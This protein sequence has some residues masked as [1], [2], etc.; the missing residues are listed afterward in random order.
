MSSGIRLACCDMTYRAG[1]ELWN[2]RTMEFSLP[3]NTTVSARLRGVKHK[4]VVP[5]GEKTTA[6]WTSK[7]YSAAFVVFAK[8]DLEQ[9]CT[10]YG[11]NEKGLKFSALTF[12]GSEYQKADDAGLFVGQLGAW[13]LDQFATC[14]E[15]ADAIGSVQIWAPAVSLFQLH[16]AISDQEGN[17]ISLRYD[18]GKAL[19]EKNPVGILTNDP[20]LTIQLQNLG[21]YNHLKSEPPAP[22]EIN[23]GVVAPPP[24]SA[25][26]TGLP[27]GFSPTDRFCRLGVFARLMELPSQKEAMVHGFHLANAMD[28][29][30][31]VVK[32]EEGEKLCAETQRWAVVANLTEPTLY[33][34]D[35]NNMNV[36]GLKVHQFA[37]NNKPF[38][39]FRVESEGQPVEWMG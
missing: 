2:M 15:V 32:M 4:G 21:N 9:G 33:F 35:H 8:P 7:Y 31:G 38:K 25:G 36:R 16:F 1:A 26:L 3:M 10:V 24:E 22:V 39:E 6:G 34:R 17:N 28:I 37:V 12:R 29:P 27:G 23:G 13:V 20:S 14:Q 30:K 11:L 18:G 5:P 19:I